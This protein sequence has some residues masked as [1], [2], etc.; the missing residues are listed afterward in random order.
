MTPYI[1]VPGTWG[2]RDRDRPDAWFRAGSPFACEVAALGLV[3]LRADP[4]LWTTRV[5]GTEGWRRW[6]AWVIPAS[7][8]R[9]DHLDWLACAEALRWYDEVNGHRA[10][11]VIAHSHGG[12]G[13]A[14]A[15]ARGWLRPRLFMTVSTPPRADMDDVYVAVR[16]E[17][18]RHGGR[19][20]HV[21]AATLDFWQRAGVGGDGR[22][23]LGSVGA[24]PVGTAHDNYP[25][26]G[27]GHTR[28]LHD[29]AFARRWLVDTGRLII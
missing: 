15:I 23:T 12:Q 1:A 18:D 6:F 28:V 24:M 17:L 2:W 16:M 11:V 5:N 3:P 20:R 25:V 7:W 26:P 4:F 13:A 27:A 9:G 10:V 8:E 19:W 21:H 14:Y 29:P 22:I